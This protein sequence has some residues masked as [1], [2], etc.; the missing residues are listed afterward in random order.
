[1]VKKKKQTNKQNRTKQS[2]TKQNR[3]KHINIVILLFFPIVKYV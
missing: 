1:M 3:T 2:N